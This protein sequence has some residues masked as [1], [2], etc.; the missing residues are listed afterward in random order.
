MR[1]NFIRRVLIVAMAAAM[2]LLHAGITPAKAT[3]MRDRMTEVRNR[4]GQPVAA[5]PAL[6]PAEE[7]QASGLEQNRRAKN[8]IVGLAIESDSLGGY[9]DFVI[10]RGDISSV[11]DGQMTTFTADS[12]DELKGIAYKL[13][14]DG[15]STLDEDIRNQIAVIETDD[16]Y[17]LDHRT[18]LDFSNMPSLIFAAIGFINVD[19]PDEYQGMFDGDFNL[20][21]VICGLGNITSCANMF[22]DCASLA[23]V[24]LGY[25][26][27]SHTTNMEA[28]FYNCMALEELDLTY[29]DFSQV[30]N[31]DFMLW[32]CERLQTL[33]ISSFDSTV[34]PIGSGMFGYTYSLVDITLGENWGKGWAYD[35]VDG[36][37]SALAEGYWT[38]GD[39]IKTAKQLADNYWNNRSEWQGVWTKLLA[40]ESIQMSTNGMLINWQ[41]LNGAEK[42]AVYLNDERI[43]VVH[44]PRCSFTKFMMG[45]TPHIKI[46][47]KIGTKTHKLVIDA[48]FNP[49]EDVVLTSDYFAA[50]AWAYN[51]GIVNGTSETTFTPYGNCTRAQFCIMLWKMAGKPSVSGISCPFTDLDGLSANNVKAIT[52]CYGQGII[53]G[54]SATTFAPKNKITRTQLTLMLWKLA[55][56][57]SVSGMSCPFVDLDG[58]SAN[59]IKAIVWA[60]NNDIDTG[61]TSTLF[62]PSMKGTRA[63]LVK[64]LLGYDNINN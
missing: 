63:Q 22:Y 3:T 17:E 35:P 40:L 31:T 11:V 20:T 19:Q 2:V 42:Y 52:W 48:T 16:M 32:G 36:A 39:E 7:L 33:D 46:T 57:P 56:K 10:V 27:T 44:Y 54:T 14:T 26:D 58:L 53:N 5:C 38:N 25:M 50:V 45:E 24:D 1:R 34:T 64:M 51:N 21:F 18:T 12:G 41:P 49:F 6:H 8:G 9:Y 59:N 62:K 29:L 30:R 28:M 13:Y 4:W 37:P 55:G 23:E 61:M 60:Y 15:F 43:T 47:S